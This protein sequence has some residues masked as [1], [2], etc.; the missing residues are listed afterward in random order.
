MYGVREEIWAFSKLINFKHPDGIFLNT[1][2]VCPIILQEKVGQ[3]Y[4]KNVLLSDL[5]V[6]RYP[7]KARFLYN[8]TLSELRHA[9]PALICVS[10]DEL[11]PEKLHYF[12]FA[13]TSASELFLFTLDKIEDQRTCNSGIVITLYSQCCFFVKALQFLSIVMKVI[14]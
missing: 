7:I 14:C 13:L 5:S 12:I 3:F 10:Q 11:S 6:D 9:E 1:D 4:L 2:P 8:L